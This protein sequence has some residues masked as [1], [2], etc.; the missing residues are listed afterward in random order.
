MIGSC[1]V[2]M[3]FTIRE[4]QRSTYPE[5]HWAEVYDALLRPA[6]EATGLRSDRDDEDCASRPI[7]LSIFGKI[8]AADIILCDVSTSNPNVFIE[9]GWALRA[10]KPYVIVM[11][12][13]TTAPFDVAD[14][15]RFHYTHTLRPRALKEQIPKLAKMLV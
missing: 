8:E 3:P 7:S 12:E 15:N 6:L 13:L 10:D 14:F 5:N 9:L 11:D 2:I 4:S 1:L